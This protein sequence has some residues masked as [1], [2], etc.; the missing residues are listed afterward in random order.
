MGYIALLGAILILTACAPTRSGTP[1][2]PDIR[3]S[4]RSVSIKREVALPNRAV[5]WACLEVPNRGIECS[6]GSAALRMQTRGGLGDHIRSR[7]ET[8]LRAAGVFSSIDETGGNA[9]ITLWTRVIQLVPTPGMC[10][11]SGCYGPQLEVQGTLRPPAG[12]I[13]WQQSVTVN[14]FPIGSKIPKRTLTAYGN[15]PELIRQDFIA[16][17]DQAVDELIRAMVPGGR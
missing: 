14:A 2:P 6:A 5:D 13:L 8:G 10:G 9:E 7:F 4:V 1:L 11:I 3:T 15:T 17:A 12:T 16:A